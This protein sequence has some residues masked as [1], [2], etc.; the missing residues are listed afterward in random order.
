MDQ[1][2]VLAASGMRARLQTLDL[3][4]NNMANSSTNG[5]K[6]DGEFYS[7]YTSESAAGELNDP[8][9]TVPMI[10][11]QWTDF[12]QG[13]LETTNNP[14]DFGLSGKG[15][16]VANGPSGPLYT[17]NG[18]FHVSSDGTLLT[19][20]NYPLLDQNNLPITTELNVPIKVA[21]D[22]TIYQ[23]DQVLTQLKIVNFKDT[24][25]LVKQGS[26]YFKNTTDQKPVDATDVEV[27]QG[28][29]EDANT[30]PAKGAVRLVNI[31]RQFEIMQKAVS[32]SNEMGQ[33]AIQ[34]VARVS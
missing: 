11:R 20:D 7:L 18:T 12:A 26:T 16:F 22:G 28:Q 9:A 19:T 17:R 32:I 25:A 14:F 13:L 23:R 29:I 30:S 34:E 33:K 1:I 6:A 5:Y 8:A 10:E 24:S 3:L 15:F 31:M 2:S 4:A 27:H 21:Q